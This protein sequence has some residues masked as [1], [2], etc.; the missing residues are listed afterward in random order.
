MHI[1]FNLKNGLIPILALIIFGCGIGNRS[2][3]NG[4]SEFK[5]TDTLEIELPLEFLSLTKWTTYNHQDKQILVEYGPGSNNSLVI[6]QVDF[7]LGKYLEPIII[8]QQGPNGYNSG[9]ASVYFKTRDSL[10][11]YPVGSP[12]FYLYNSSGQLVKKYLYNA[13]DYSSYTVGGYYSTAVFLNEK[14]FIPTAQPLRFDDPQIFTKLTPIRSFDFDSNQFIDSIAY[15]KYTKN[16]SITID[17]L[18]PSLAGINKDS[19]V[20]NYR[21]SD[22]VYFWN[23]VSNK[24]SSLYLSDDKFGKPKLFDRYPGRAEG[25]E[26]KVREVDFGT[27]I[28]HNKR[29]FR[30]INYVSKKDKSLEAFEI[31]QYDKRKMAL[32]E[33]DLETK[34]KKLYE[35]ALAKYLTFIDDYLFVG[36]VSI[37]EDGDKT[38]RTFL[39]Y[40]LE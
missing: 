30:I 39:R 28:Y 20:I 9:G 32:L 2:S 33:Y 18:S 11:V 14:M 7:L 37:R 6:H 17:R 12:H 16:K 19:L 8:P 31:L 3:E 27:T 15:P 5:S 23:P 21:F 26:F 25:I 36:G 24:L 10:F 38:L 35:L 1:S 34:T 4:F 22:S 13:I 40:K 29:L